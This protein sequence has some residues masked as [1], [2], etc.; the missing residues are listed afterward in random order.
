MIIGSKTFYLTNKQATSCLIHHSKAK[1]T[2]T[3]T[4][5]HSPTGSKSMA[6]SGHNPITLTVF[7]VVVVFISISSRPSIA[8]PPFKYRKAPRFFGKF[9]YQNKPLLQQQYRYETRYFQQRLD[10]FSFTDHPK[11]SQRYLINTENWVGPNRLGP[12]FLYCGNE[13]DIEW[14][15]VNSGFVWE[16][17]PRFGAMV[18]FPEVS[19]FN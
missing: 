8:S 5:T 2:I 15:A 18:L 16:I 6:E 3:N 19:L 11:F 4:H 10:H 1:S 7:I 14:F 12:I 13:G 9:S 17:A